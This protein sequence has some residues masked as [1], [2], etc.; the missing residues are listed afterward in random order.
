MK[1]EKEGEGDDNDDDENVIRNIMDVNNIIIMIALIDNY[2]NDPYFFF[3]ISG[4][5]KG[6]GGEVVASLD[7]MLVF[8]QHP[9]LQ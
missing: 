9:N 5:T 8:E 4:A 7:K 1:R 2:H 6:Q 3:I